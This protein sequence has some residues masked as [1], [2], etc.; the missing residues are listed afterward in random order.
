MKIATIKEFTGMDNNG[1]WY[2]EGM[3]VK[4]IGGKTVLSPFY[5]NDYVASEDTTGF[6][7]INIINGGD[8]IPS[9]VSSNPNLLIIGR[10]GYIHCVD[11]VLLTGNIGLVHTPYKTATTYNDIKVTKNNN[12][13]FPNQDYLGIGY[14]DLV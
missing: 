10:T 1:L 5:Y 7:N 8:S 14:K 13:L 2:L 12:I 3:K 11:A 9:L 4:K 6:T